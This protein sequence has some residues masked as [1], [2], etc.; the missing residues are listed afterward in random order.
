VFIFYAV[1]IFMLL[2]HNVIVCGWSFCCF[3][4]PPTIEDIAEENLAVT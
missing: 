3:V 2:A 4:N 1:F